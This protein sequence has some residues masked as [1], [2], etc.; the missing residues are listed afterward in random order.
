MFVASDGR[1]ATAILADSATKMPIARAPEA[2]TD[3]YGR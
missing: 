3:T 2:T 1:V